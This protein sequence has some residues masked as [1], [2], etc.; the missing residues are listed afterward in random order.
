MA[1]A[2]NPQVRLA[3]SYNFSDKQHNFLQCLIMCK[4]LGGTKIKTLLK[5]K[6]MEPEEQGELRK[7]GQKDEG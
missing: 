3:S 5:I 4:V 1:D 6:K 7:R 2:L